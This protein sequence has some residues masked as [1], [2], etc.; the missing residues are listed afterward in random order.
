MLSLPE[1]TDAMRGRALMSCLA[2]AERA[3]HIPTDETVPLAER[4]E[5]IIEAAMGAGLEPRLFELA[6]MVRRLRAAS[7]HF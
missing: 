5:A 2:E 7:G 6:W 4:A 1:V 3:C